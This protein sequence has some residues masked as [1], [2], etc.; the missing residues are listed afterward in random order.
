MPL[1][2]SRLSFLITF[3]SSELSLMLMIT[4]LRRFIF[5]FSLFRHLTL[6]RAIDY[7]FALLFAIIYADVYADC[8]TLAYAISDD[9]CHDSWCWSPLIF[10]FDCHWLFFDI[11]IFFLILITFFRFRCWCHC[12]R[13]V[14][15]PPAAISFDYHAA[16]MILRQRRRFSPSAWWYRCQLMLMP[17]LITP[18]ADIAPLFIDYLYIADDDDADYFRHDADTLLSFWLI[19]LMLMLMLIIFFRCWFSFDSWYFIFFLFFS[20]ADATLADDIDADD[21]LMIIDAAMMILLYWCRADYFCHIFFDA[22]YAWW[23]SYASHAMISITIF[24][25]FIS[26]DAADADDFHCF[27]LMFIITPLM[28]IFSPLLMTL[29]PLLL[30]IISLLIIIIMPPLID[31]YYLLIAYW[32]HCQPLIIFY[33]YWLFL[34]RYFSRIAVRW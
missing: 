12:R 13:H 15:P 7:A 2:T 14:S 29:M 9:W 28:L 25:L 16:T 10:A 31:I 21:A 24:L 33:Y 26:T 11:F 4:P 19:T 6:L 23:F 27:T 1:I 22:I 34:F 8:H 17:P 5:F 18:Y 30:L 20:D 32:W 3:S